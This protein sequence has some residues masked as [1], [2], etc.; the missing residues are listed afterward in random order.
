MKRYATIEQNSGFVWWVG[1]ADSPEDACV[2]SH[3]EGDREAISFERKYGNNTAGGYAVYEVPA[4]FDVDD[5]Q[6]QRQIEATAAFP[7]VGVFIGIDK[8]IEDLPF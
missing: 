6:D 7:M 4:D 5:G 1:E 3:A 2:K 8:P